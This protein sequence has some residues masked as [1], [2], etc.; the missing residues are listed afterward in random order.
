MI[1]CGHFR[2]IMG[3]ALL[4]SAVD[5]ARTPRGGRRP[6]SRAEDAR[7]YAFEPF[8][9]NVMSW[10]NDWW[11]WVV[12]GTVFFLTMPGIYIPVA[13]ALGFF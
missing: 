2:S 4:S 9:A 8:G 6:R 1:W 5:H 10:D 13:M 11:S 12:I 3:L 7:Q